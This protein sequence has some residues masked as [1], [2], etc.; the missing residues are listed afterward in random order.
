MAQTVGRQR[1]VSVFSGIALLLFCG[2]VHGQ[3][4]MPATALWQGVPTEEAHERV[5]RPL[6]RVQMSDPIRANLVRRILDEASRLLLDPECRALLDEFQDQRG[7][8][9]AERLHA[10]GVDIQT[11]LSWIVFTDNMGPRACVRD[12]LAV[13]M[14]GSRVVHV[15]DA[16]LEGSWRRNPQHVVASFIHETLHTLGLG[17]NPPASSDITKRVIARCRIFQGTRRR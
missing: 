2:I 15:C 7:R 14:P 6:W 17:E 4:P 10:F 3:A 16:Y 1:L 5:G 12:A 13:T 9:L 8:T 11:Y